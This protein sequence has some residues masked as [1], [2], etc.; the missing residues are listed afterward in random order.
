[1]CS[2]RRRSLGRDTATRTHLKT[3]RLIQRHLQ[4]RLAAGAVIAL[5]ASAVFV[6]DAVAGSVR[7]SA[8]VTGATAPAGT[9][10]A[11]QE[12]Y[13]RLP[14]TFRPN[15]GQADSAIAFTAASGPNTLAL[16]GSGVSVSLSRD[17]T[18]GQKPGVDLL[19][20]AKLR[21]IRAEGG[22]APATL[23]VRFLGG[24]ANATGTGAAPV[25]R[26]ANYILR[27]DPAGWRLG[28]PGFS[29]VVFHDVYPGIDVVY[30]SVG[31]DLEYDF[32]VAPGAS[33][34]PIAMTFVGAK[35]IARG[36]SGEIVLTIDGGQVVQDAPVAYQTSGQSRSPVTAEYV[37]N[38]NGTFGL[39][40]GAY[41]HTRALTVD[42]LLVFSTFLGGTGYDAAYSIA[43]D[44]AGNSYVAG[45]TGSTDFPG[46]GVP[47]KGAGHVHAFVSK[48]NPAGSALVYSTYVGGSSD[49][50]ALGIAVDSSGAAYVTAATVSA[51]LPLVAPTY[52]TY[53]GGADAFAFKLN[54]VGSALSYS[55]YLGGTGY[56]IGYGVAGGPPPHAFL[57]RPT[58]SAH[59]LP[60]PVPPDAAPPPG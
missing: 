21:T 22:Q 7:A 34:A 10:P 44:G 15:R 11:V 26:V 32:V 3:G 18:A 30:R 8:P 42:P 29:S 40:L 14:L 39:K 35:H 54:A 49:D 52:S 59:L 51:D 48:L 37:A 56:D 6:P 46:A 55:S 38:A 45:L 28:V 24:N 23:G 33:T 43:I 25:R 27:R 16:S 19:G 31:Q 47:A 20:D 53:G 12:A 17:T 9:K 50:E 5:L 4:D 13:G 58:S 2:S 1:M 41:D 60:P 36:A 57:S